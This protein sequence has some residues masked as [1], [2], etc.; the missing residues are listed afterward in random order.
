M[1]AEA[2]IELRRAINGL[3]EGKCHILWRGSFRIKKNIQ[4]AKSG[5]RGMVRRD[6]GHQA[7]SSI[8]W[9]WNCP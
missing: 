4:I 1:A 8:E 2:I 9:L 6:S 5:T 7:H 3:S